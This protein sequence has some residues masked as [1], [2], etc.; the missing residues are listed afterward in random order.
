MRLTSY[1]TAL[2]RDI[3]FVKSLSLSYIYIITYI[4]KKIKKD[5][6]LGGEDGSQT[7]DLLNAIQT[8]SQLSYIP[9]YLWCLEWDSNPQN[10]VFETATYAIPSPR[11]IKER[12]SVDSSYNGFAPPVYTALR[13]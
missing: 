4:F 3:S 12:K 6:L 13:I 5:L 9:I 7:H 10:A 2:P 11:H 8:L 1:L